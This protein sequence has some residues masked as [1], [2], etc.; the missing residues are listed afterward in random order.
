MLETFVFDVCAGEKNR[1]VSD[2][3]A[4][5][6]LE[7]IDRVGKR[8]VFMLVSGGVDSTVAFAL[9]NKALGVDRVL[10]VCIDT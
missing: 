2:A 6:C 7:I 3:V 8:N 9:L 4:S 10:G 1:E 5:L